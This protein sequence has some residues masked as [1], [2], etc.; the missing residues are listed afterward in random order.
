M[1]DFTENYTLEDER[2]LL[3]PLQIEDLAIFVS[4]YYR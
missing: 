1:F 3:R 4:Y 2:V